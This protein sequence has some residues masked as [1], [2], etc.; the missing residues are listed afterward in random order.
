MSLTE[1]DLDF[2]DVFYIRVSSL[3]QTNPGK[4]CFH[5]NTTVTYINW[6]PK[7]YYKTREREYWRDVFEPFGL[8]LSYY[9]GQWRWVPEKDYSYFTS[10]TGLLLPFV[11]ED[12][13]HIK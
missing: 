8:L 7:R 13:S 3:R 1:D 5:D 9:D 11:C 10:D 6:I 2:D 4:Y 12:R